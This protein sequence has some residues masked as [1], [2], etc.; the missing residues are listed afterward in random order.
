MRNLSHHQD[1]PGLNGV[2]EETESRKDWLC[3]SGGLHDLRVDTLG[4]VYVLLQIGGL[5]PEQYCSVGWVVFL[6][7]LADLG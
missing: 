6:A 3:G 5:V 7:G 2:E 4:L 1:H